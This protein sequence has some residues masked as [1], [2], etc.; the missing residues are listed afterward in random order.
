M[1]SRSEFLFQ[2]FHFWS[3]CPSI[4]QLL[5]VLTFPSNGQTT[6]LDQGQGVVQTSQTEFPNCGIIKRAL[7]DS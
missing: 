1:W 3:I 5:C 7:R 6:S 2:S 4:M